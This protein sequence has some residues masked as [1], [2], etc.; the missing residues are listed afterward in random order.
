M[1]QFYLGN[2]VLNQLQLGN[3]LINRVRV[4]PFDSDAQV[5]IDRVINQGGSL[6]GDQRDAVTLFFKEL[7]FKNIYSKLYAM[8]P[9]LGG[10]AASN[11]IDAYNPGSSF[12]ITFNGTWTH[13]NNLGS[14][15]NADVA[16]FADT[17][18]NPTINASSV[19]TNFSFG[20]LAT[21]G[22]EDGR[23]GIST[24]TPGNQ[25][26][27]GN[28]SSTQ[29]LVFFGGSRIFTV[30]AGGG[31]INGALEVVS[32]QNTN[33]WYGGYVSDGTLVSSATTNTYTALSRTIYIGRRNGITSFPAG[34][35]IRF[36]F[37]GEYLSPAEMQDFSNAINTLQIAFSRNLWA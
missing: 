21:S 11:N 30:P 24:A 15:T 19:T 32:R 16:N 14:V 18:F 28:Q 33:D 6:S 29:I 25:I 34:G 35:Q 20:L 7:K 8:W 1:T 2:T 27:L 9:F 10:V 3:T 37:V 17:N 36:G 26:S 22:S 23:H 13:S 31:F 12:D 5:Y 4:R